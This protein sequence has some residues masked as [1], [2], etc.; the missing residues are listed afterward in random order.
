MTRLRTA[1]IAIATAGAM[2]AIAPALAQAAVT[3]SDITT[4]ASSES[5][6]PQNSTYLISY[7]NRSTTLTVSGD[8]TPGSGNVDVVCYFGSGAHVRR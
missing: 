5:G 8:A 1:V 6:T 3:S 7:D 2:L 4:W